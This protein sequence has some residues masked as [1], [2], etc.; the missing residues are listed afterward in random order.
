LDVD[1]KDPV[2][3]TELRDRVIIDLSKKL[4][5]RD[6]GNV[7]FL[8]EIARPRLRD[9]AP[10]KILLWEMGHYQDKA[11]TPSSLLQ[12]LRKSAPTDA[13]GNQAALQTVHPGFRFGRT[14]Q[15]LLTAARENRD[16]LA[17][18]ALRDLG[19]KEKDWDRL[20]RSR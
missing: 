3:R 19:V 13:A 18:R 14:G 11:G 1:S 7:L 17:V 12:F 6:P 5:E 15:R 9:A 4:L 20:R 16:P 2:E 10:W 8:E